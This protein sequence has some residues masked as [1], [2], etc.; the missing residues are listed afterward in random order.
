MTTFGVFNDTDGPDSTNIVDGFDPTKKATVT[1]GLAVKVDATD[2]VQPVVINSGVVGT[3][4]LGLNNLQT[5]Q[6]IVSTTAVQLASSSLP[7]RS[8]M[9]VKVTTTSNQDIVY[10]GVSNLVTSSNGYALFNG[11]SIQLDITPSGHVWAI[12]TNPG[13]LVY[14]MEVGI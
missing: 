5:S 1:A 12:A 14:I 13:Q 3:N 11:D 10:L 6:Q 8:S 4:I 2:T 9:S 7:T